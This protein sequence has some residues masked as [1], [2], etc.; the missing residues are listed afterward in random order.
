MV[1]YRDEKYIEEFEVELQKKAGKPLG[2][3]LKGYKDGKGAYISEI[4][5]SNYII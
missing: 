3:Y 5:R 1:I 2:L 4:V